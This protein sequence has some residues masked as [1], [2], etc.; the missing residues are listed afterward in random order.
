[1]LQ[2]SLPWCPKSPRLWNEICCLL[3]LFPG[4]LPL[5]VGLPWWGKPPKMVKPGPQ[6]CLNLTTVKSRG[7][8]KAQPKLRKDPQ[9]WESKTYSRSVSH[10]WA[11]PMGYVQHWK[12]RGQVITLMKTFME[13]V[14]QNSK[15]GRGKEEWRR[16]RQLENGLGSPMCFENQLFKF[17]ENLMGFLIKTSLNL[18]FI[19]GDSTSLYFP[20]HEHAISSPFI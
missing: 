8:L 1:M 10:G 15:P 16:F 11:S 6:N 3:G 19:C 2:F 4:L 7:E 9:S 5:Q 17:C 13:W 18:W 20:N 14:W 12:K